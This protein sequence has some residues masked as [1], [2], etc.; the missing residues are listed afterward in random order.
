VVIRKKKSVDEREEKEKR[1]PEPGNPRCGSLF[2]VRAI[3]LPPRFPKKKK[4]G[5]FEKEGGRKEKGGEE[6][7][8]FHVFG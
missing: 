5:D 1:Y 3:C 2:R 7:P 4:R 8:G 6:Q